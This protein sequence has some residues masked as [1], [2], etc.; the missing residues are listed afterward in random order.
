[1]MI[2]LLRLRLAMTSR[3][4]TFRGM[5]DEVWARLKP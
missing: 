2:G 1:M 3:G 4:Q 5:L